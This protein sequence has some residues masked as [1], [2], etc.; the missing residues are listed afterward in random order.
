MIYRVHH[1]VQSLCE[2]LCILCKEPYIHDD[3]QLD[4]INSI[5]LLHHYTLH[6]HHLTSSTPFNHYTLHLTH[7]TSSTP[8]H[9]Y[10]LHH[11]SPSQ[12]HTTSRA[13]NCERLYQIDNGRHLKRDFAFVVAE[14]RELFV[15]SELLVHKHIFFK[16]NSL[17][18]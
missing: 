15:G 12:L 16:V 13:Q 8:F 6:L 14:K 5:H 2:E 18:T 4:N 9:H 3:Q 10:T 11:I 1:L 17:L 7:L